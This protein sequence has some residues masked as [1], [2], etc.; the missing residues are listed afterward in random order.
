MMELF[1]KGRGQCWIHE[2]MIFY[3]VLFTI[4]IFLPEEYFFLS[5]LLEIIFT[6]H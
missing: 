6:V 3:V 2:F 1:G 5:F 4:Y